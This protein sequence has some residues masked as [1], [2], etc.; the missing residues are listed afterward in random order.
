MTP[1]IFARVASLA[2]T[3]SWQTRVLNWRQKL[4]DLGAFFLQKYVQ[5]ETLYERG[6]REHSGP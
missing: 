6:S 3:G 1:F 4:S 2:L 5:K